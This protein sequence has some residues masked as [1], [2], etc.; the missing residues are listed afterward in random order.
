MATSVTKYL[1]AIDSAI[2]SHRKKHTNKDELKGALAATV[3]IGVQDDEL[4][5]IDKKYLQTTAHLC[6]RNNLTVAELCEAIEHNK[7]LK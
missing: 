5:A 6:I 1:N 7:P 4:K 2:E 3:F